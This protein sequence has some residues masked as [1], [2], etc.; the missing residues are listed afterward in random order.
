MEELETLESTE[1]PECP[2]PPPE[3]RLPPPPR[4]PFLTDGTFCSEEPLT[5]IEDC[6]AIPMIDASYHTNPSLQS[7]ALIIT[8][9]VVLLLMAAI[10]SVVFWKHKRKVQNLLPCK[11]AAGSAAAAAAAAASGRSGGAVLY[12]DLPD[13]VSH[14]QLHNHLPPHHPGQA[15]T[16]E[17]RNPDQRHSLRERQ[18]QQLPRAR[19]PVPHHLDYLDYRDPR[20][21]LR[22]QDKPSRAVLGGY[23]TPRAL[24]AKSQGVPLSIA[25]HTPPGC[26]AVTS[27]LLQNGGNVLRNSHLLLASQNAL[28]TSPQP[29]SPTP[30]TVVPC[31]TIC[32]DAEITLNSEKYL[33][34]SCVTGRPIDSRLPITPTHRPRV[35]PLSE[36][37]QSSL[38]FTSGQLQQ[39]IA[40]LLSRDELSNSRRPSVDSEGYSYI[41]FKDTE[42]ES[43]RYDTNRTRRP[44]TGTTRITSLRLFRSSTVRS[45]S[46]DADGYSYILDSGFRKAPGTARRIV[47]EGTEEEVCPL[48]TMQQIHSL[49][50]KPEDVYLNVQGT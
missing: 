39:P 6:V 37:S 21:I 12:E 41:D 27:P 4:P 7:T 48:C 1:C 30:C 45:N 15:P 17:V 35:Q 24:L 22:V 20:A 46:V 42:L 19:P 50:S 40:G 29:L 3:F 47:A 13:A 43:T 16:I 23:R 9:A 49:L 44:D 38:N 14:S 11:S 10:V 34:D 36:K 26:N 28:I 31:V 18:P 8:C 2:G 5:E 32:P 33:G 25:T